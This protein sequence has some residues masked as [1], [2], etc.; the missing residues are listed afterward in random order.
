MTD[1][2]GGKRGSY[3]KAFKR[4]V[5]AETLASGASVSSVARKHGLNANMVFGW[6]ND[7]RF[8]P[9]PD[10]GSFLPVEVIEPDVPAAPDI[11]AQDGAGSIEIVLSNGHR[12][13]VQGDVDPD[14]VLVLAQ[15]LSS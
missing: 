10:A 8:G 4:R 13:S 12:L 2:R 5:V 11:T 14:V 3:S 6:R 1:W 15:G 7:P 9:G